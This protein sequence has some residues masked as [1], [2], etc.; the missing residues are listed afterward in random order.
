MSGKVTELRLQYP[1]MDFL[2]HHV[3]SPTKQKKNNHI[4]FKSHKTDPW[5]H[6]AMGQNLWYHIWVDEHPFTI[7][8]DVHQGTTVLTHGH[9]VSNEIEALCHHVHM[10]K[11]TWCS[12]YTAG[13][14]SHVAS[15]WEIP[16]SSWERC[17][18]YNVAKLCIVAFT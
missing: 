18:S 7:Y 9:M 4:W 14:K 10:V 8:F 2:T 13:Q 15:R 17:K 6:M 16:Y 3:Q 1:L 12:N 5:F 11:S